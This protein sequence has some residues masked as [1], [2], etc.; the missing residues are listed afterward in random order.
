[1]VRIVIAVLVITVSALLI[2]AQ[3]TEPQQ[4]REPI[5]A[6]PERVVV[7]ISAAV[8]ALYT[9]LGVLLKSVWA[10]RKELQTKLLEIQAKQ[11][12]DFQA[13]SADR[14]EQIAT[15]R[16]SITHLSELIERLIAEL[17]E[18]RHARKQ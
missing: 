5:I 1:M 9:G 4:G 8:A 11:L 7:W 14:W 6:I 15:D 16:A 2:L 18:S 17:R 13:F 10:D 3:T 12:A